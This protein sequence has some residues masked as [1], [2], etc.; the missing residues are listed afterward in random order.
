[1]F[2]VTPTMPTN[3]LLSTIRQVKSLGIFYIPLI[4]ML[5][6]IVHSL[7]GLHLETNYLQKYKK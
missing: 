1:M 7:S 3:C 6:R 4:I 5:H 2:L